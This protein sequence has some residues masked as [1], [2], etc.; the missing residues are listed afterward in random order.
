MPLIP[1]LFER[2]Y[3]SSKNVS[4][5]L[6]IVSHT[7]L[8][9]YAIEVTVRTLSGLPESERVRSALYNEFTKIRIGYRLP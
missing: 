8:K 9:L 3:S 4:T 7:V 6:D 2:A 5:V 1:Q